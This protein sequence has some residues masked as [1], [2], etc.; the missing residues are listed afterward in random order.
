MDPSVLA[1]SIAAVA[2]MAGAVMSFVNGRR[3]R[4]VEI[5][6]NGK[7]AALVE[8][9]ARA[10][11]AEGQAEGRVIEAAAVATL[12]AVGTPGE[13]GSVVKV[14]VEGEMAE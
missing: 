13:V 1:A 12:A 2:A 5:S 3:I 9:T 10:E 4:K 8:A 7:L 14:I 11:R 6:V